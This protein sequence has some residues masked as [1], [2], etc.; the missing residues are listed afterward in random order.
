M[1]PEPTKNDA[2]PE[3]SDLEGSALGAFPVVQEEI[4]AYEKEKKE[5]EKGLEAG[6]EKLKFKVSGTVPTGSVKAP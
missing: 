5:R 3:S 1:E 4:E 2:E 6:P